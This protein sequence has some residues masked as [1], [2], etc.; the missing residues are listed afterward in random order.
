MRLSV[1]VPFHRDLTKLHKCLA[2]VRAAAQQLPPETAHETIVVA[3]GSPDDPTV[4]AAANGATVAPIDGPRGPA[5]AR[6]RGAAIA[7]GD[8]LI[9]VDSDVVIHGAS[10]AQL[11]RT[12]VLD[13][14]LAAVI[15]AYDEHPSDTG[16]VSQ[17]KNLA[18]SFIHQRAKGDARTFWA[19]LGA[20]RAAVFAS[21][22]G[23]D[24]RLTRP[25]VEDIDLGYRIRAAGGRI[26]LDPAIQGQHL[27]R[28]TLTSA[29]LTEIRDR[30]IPWTQLL[31][32]YG[33]LHDDLNVTLSYRACVVT[34]YVLAVCV[35]LSPRLPIL[36]VPA[37]LAILMLWLLDRSYY[38][39]FARRCG[40]A[41]AMAWFPVHVLHHLCNGLSFVVGTLLYAGRR[42][43]GLSLPGALPVT[44][45]SA[46]EHRTVTVSE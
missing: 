4:E 35:L 5:T 25:S 11:A 8:V 16:F 32:R 36:L 13:P 20:V 2:G 17:G 27:K 34:A 3:D 7:S 45:W 37:A 46:T 41:Y 19:G 28:W 31:H 12:F 10:L 26:V 43:T 24:E 9:F 22:G 21:V 18:H 44:P 1:I 40:P 23:F 42:W 39:F 15:G 30:G 6:N 38:S 29:V 33:G 14:E